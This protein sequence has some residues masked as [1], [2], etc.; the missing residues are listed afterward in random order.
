MFDARCVVNS[1]GDKLHVETWAGLLRN[2]SLR[3]SQEKEIVPGCAVVVACPSCLDHTPVSPGRIIRN[4]L[5][6][7]LE[8][9]A[10]GS[11]VWLS[12]VPFEGRILSS[13]FAAGGLGGD[14]IVPHSVVGSL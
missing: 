14:G 6:W 4:V 12:G 3:F 11:G 5:G 8:E 9:K 7:T 1:V 10:D 2:R 13:L